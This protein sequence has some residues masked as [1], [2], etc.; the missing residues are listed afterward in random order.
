M[1]ETRELFQIEVLLAAVEL[2]HKE[3]I[4]QVVTMAL[5]EELGYPMQ[6]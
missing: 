3:Q 6:F 2:E 1:V 5:Q 4:I